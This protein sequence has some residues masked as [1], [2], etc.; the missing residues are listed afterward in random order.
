MLVAVQ[1]GDEVVVMDLEEF[2]TLIDVPRDADSLTH[3]F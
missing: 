2:V 1:N 3:E